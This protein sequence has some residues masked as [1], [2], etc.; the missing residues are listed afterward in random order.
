MVNDALWSYQS[1]YKTLIGTTS[2]NL[3]YRKYCHLSIELERNAYWDIKALN[4]DFKVV[5]DK[6]RSQLS[7]LEELKVDAYENAKLYKERT[8]KWHDK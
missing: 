4:M 3:V 5:G 2:F 8:K 7:E 6:R 1:A